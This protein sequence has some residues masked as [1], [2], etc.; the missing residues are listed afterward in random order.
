M[1]KHNVLGELGK[2]LAVEEFEKNGYEIVEH[3]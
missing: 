1:A 3:N 2:D